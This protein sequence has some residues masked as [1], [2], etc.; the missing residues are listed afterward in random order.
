MKSF[1]KG[2]V[3]LFCIKYL[4]NKKYFTRKIVVNGDG[5]GGDNGEVV[6]VDEIV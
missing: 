5:G 6:V 2:E 3:C 1:F 4:T